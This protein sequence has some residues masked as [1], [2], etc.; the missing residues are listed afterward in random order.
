MPKVKWR[1]HRAQKILFCPDCGKRFANET[2]VLQHMN[3]PSIACGSWLNDLSRLHFERRAPAAPNGT[4]AHPYSEFQDFPAP[5]QYENDGV[6][7]ADG[8][9]AHEDAAHGQVDEYPDHTSTPVVD[10]H[11]NIPS[12]YPGGTTFADQFSNDPHATHRT[13]NLYY[14]FASS[15]DWQLASWLLRSR[16]SMAA[17]DEFLSL[18]LVR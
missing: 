8:F 6:D 11:P 14:P 3:Q 16:L 12:I 2:R 15:A 9:G 7:G 4:E 17:I 10:N 5:D 13:E 18:H 1:L